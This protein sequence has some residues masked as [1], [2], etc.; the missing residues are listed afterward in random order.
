[1][2]T[3][4]SIKKIK[5]EAKEY[6][7][8]YNLK[9]TVA[10]NKIA[11]KYGFNKFEILKNESNKNNGFIER[12][13][14]LS[15]NKTISKAFLGASGTGKS[16]ALREE[17]R[18]RVED[19]IIRENTI[20]FYILE[21]EYSLYKEKFPDAKFIF[22]E[23]Q[24]ENI[25]SYDTI[26]IDIGIRISNNLIEKIEVTNILMTFQAAEDLFHLIPEQLMNENFPNFDKYAFIEYVANTKKCIVIDI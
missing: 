10:L 5:Q 21:E 11:E 16:F 13:R 1:M 4:I 23:E 12:T 15:G 3:Q 6:K 7:N 18:R 8:Q 14:S 2:P 17:L 22:S 19:E 24:F 26:V 25:N 9:H 20:L